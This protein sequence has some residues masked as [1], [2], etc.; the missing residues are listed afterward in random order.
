MHPNDTNNMKR[1]IHKELSYKITG[2]CFQA[3]KKLGRFCREKQYADKL[4]ELFKQAGISYK[5]EVDLGDLF[6]ESPKGNRADF[7]I[8]NKILLD[9]KAKKFITKDD[10]NQMQR[11]LRAADFDLGLVVNFRNTYL[12]PKRVLN[13]SY[14]GHS[15]INSDNSYRPLGFTL[16]E[17]MISLGIVAIILVAFI[18]IQILVRQSYQFS[19]NTYVTVNRANSVTEQ[20]VRTIR[21]ARAA[22]NGAYALEVFND[23]ELAFYA[24][25]D[26]DSQAERV[27]YFLEG[28]EL[29]RGVIEPTGF[30][31]TYPSE[32]EAVKV[33]TE[34]VRNGS[35]PVFYYYNRDWPTDTTNNPLPLAQRL[36]ETQFIQVFFKI[37]VNPDRP[38]GEFV[39][40]PYV[41]LRNLKDNL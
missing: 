7:L 27:R 17:V 35:D 20:L 13:S 11:Y 38:E 24:D 31:V 22:D 36:N 25:I 29:K 8:E 23:Q 26:N 18:G 2:L 9:A 39:L 28:E 3:H 19:F 6:P 40:S 15:D 41:Q 1:I 33:M 4:E 10:Y 12:K 37:N 34:Y 5:R 14:S 32:N 21:R 30:P 16:L